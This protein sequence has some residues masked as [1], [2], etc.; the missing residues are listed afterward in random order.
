[1]NNN[2]DVNIICGLGNY[3]YKY[4]HTRH[5]IG[6]TILDYIFINKK[7]SLLC[8]N[9]VRDYSNQYYNVIEVQLF[10]RLIFCIKP[11]T[12][13]N[14]CGVVISKFL[15]EYNLSYEKMLVIHDDMDIRLGDINIKINS[16]D[17]GHKGIK[18]IID[19]LFSKNFAKLRIGIG[20]CNPNKVVAEYVLEKFDSRV[21]LDKV[22]DIINIIL[23][24]GLQKAMNIYN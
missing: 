2:L 4:N 8:D 1:M 23:C 19:S 22:V 5:N 10:N 17:A 20:R 15:K 9:I 11:L 12:Y 21:F 14:N 7:L 6:F 24:F 13:M 18:S 3:G 16:G